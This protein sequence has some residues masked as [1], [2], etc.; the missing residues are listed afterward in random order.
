VVLGESGIGTAP[1]DTTAATI[2]ALLAD[3]PT[4]QLHDP[5]EVAK[6]LPAAEILGPTTLAYLTPDQFHPFAGPDIELLPVDHP[7]LRVLESRCSPEERDE[8]S[9]DELTSPVFVV[10]E[11]GAVI[12]AA[13]YRAWPRDT[14]HMAILTAPRARGRGLAKV[15]ASSAVK[16]AIAAGMLPQW[17]ARVPASQH[18]ARALGF[19]EFGPQ[20]SFKLA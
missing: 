5:E 11:N 19:T 2:R 7:D 4:E 14:A 15:T 3:Y 1:D 20:I 12:A 13:G 17:R 8:A 18:V 16:H 10:R 9:M 6:L